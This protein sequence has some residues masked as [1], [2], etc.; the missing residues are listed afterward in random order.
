DVLEPTAEWVDGADVIPEL[1]RRAKVNLT[2][3]LGS[4]HALPVAMA[5]DVFESV[6]T[7]LFDNA[8]QHGGVNVKVEVIDASVDAFKILVSDDGPG[9][10]PANADKVF[11]SF[12]TTA[13][14]DGGTGLG[15]SIAKSL[16]QRH[17]GDIQLTPAEGRGASFLL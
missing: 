9:I 11:A 2:L 16:L 12:F 8:A 4:L 6:F 15:L 3:D 14:D 1:A 10:S 13:R 17:G 7:N 5:F